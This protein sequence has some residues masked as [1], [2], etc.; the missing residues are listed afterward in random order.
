MWLAQWPQIEWVYVDVSHFVVISFPIGNWMVNISEFRMH[1]IEFCVH[2]MFQSNAIKT[3]LTQPISN[4]IFINLYLDWWRSIRNVIEVNN[5]QEIVAK[6][7]TS[8]WDWT[9]IGHFHE[10]AEFAICRKSTNWCTAN[11]LVDHHTIGMQFR[12]VGT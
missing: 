10:I 5:I 9:N 3:I 1:K 12:I 11:L 8:S 2:A 4:K 6:K 7:S